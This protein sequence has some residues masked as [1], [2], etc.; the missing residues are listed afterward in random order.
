MHTGGGY[1]LW[2]R[3]FSHISDIC[4]RVTWHNVVYHSSTSVYIPNFV[5]IGKT[6]CFLWTDG[7]TNARTDIETAFGFG[8][9]G[10]DASSKLQS[11]CGG[12]YSIQL[13]IPHR[14][15]PLAA[16]TLLLCLTTHSNWWIVIGY[17][18]SDT[19]NETSNKPQSIN[20]IKP[21]NHYSCTWQLYTYD[22][23]R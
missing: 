7:C 22:P 1:S 4:D 3:P 10:G 17:H 5:K 12:R 18:R 9:L 20:P 11:V 23:I 21:I 19:E 14:F 13:S 15:W 6:F 8:R 2:N 16:S